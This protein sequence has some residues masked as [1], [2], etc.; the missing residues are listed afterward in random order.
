MPCIVDDCPNRAPHNIGIRLRRPGPR[1]AVWA[2]DS[3]AYV[4]NEHAAA[5]MLIEIIITATNTRQIETEVR[6]ASGVRVGRRT[7]RINRRPY[8]TPPQLC[9]Y[10]DHVSCS[11]NLSKILRESVIP[12]KAS[13]KSA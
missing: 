12:K 5:G 11:P 4:C 9:A 3:A 10:I 2:P 1:T 7:T 6:S 13:Q 8:P